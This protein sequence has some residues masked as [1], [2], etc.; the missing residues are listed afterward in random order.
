MLFILQ[1]IISFMSILYLGTNLAG[2]AYQPLPLNYL[3]ILYLFFF[4]HHHY[5]LSR[6]HN[7]SLNGTSQSPNLVFPYFVLFFYGNI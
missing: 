5:F 3:L 2:G 7:F 4:I 1:I 6:G